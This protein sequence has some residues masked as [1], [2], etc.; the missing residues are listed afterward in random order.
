MDTWI[1]DVSF[2]LC[3][4][5][6]PGNPIKYAS[7]SFVDL[8]GYDANECEGKSVGPLVGGYSILCHEKDLAVFAGE[9]GVQVPAVVHGM[10]FLMDRVREL[11]ARIRGNPQARGHVLQ[12]HRR[13]DGRALVC[14]M[15]VGRGSVL[16]WPCYAVVQRPLQITP[17]ELLTASGC[18][19]ARLMQE[20]SSEMEALLA[21]F[22]GPGGEQMLTEVVSSVLSASLWQRFVAAQK[23]NP[24][25]T[26]SLGSPSTHS[27]GS[28]RSAS[29]AKSG[30]SAVTWTSS[31]DVGRAV[32]EESSPSFGVVAAEEGC[33][34]TDTRKTIGVPDSLLKDSGDKEWESVS[35][36]DFTEE[37]LSDSAVF[38]RLAPQRVLSANSRDW[39]ELHDLEFAFMLADPNLP[40][41]PIV[42][43]SDR[44]SQM[45]HLPKQALSG[46]GLDSL[47]TPSRSTMRDGLD[48]ARYGALCDDCEFNVFTAKARNAEGVLQH[49]EGE[50][51]TSFVGPWQDEGSFACL[52]LIRQVILDNV[53]YLAGV[54]S[55]FPQSVSRPCVTEE[56]GAHA[57]LVG[58]LHHNFLIAEQALAA[59]FWTSVPFHRQQR[60]AG[61]GL[62]RQCGSRF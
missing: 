24:T 36:C 47:L 30:S 57:T 16:G 51:I 19:Y 11:S 26:R 61:A 29:T 49:E 17:A 3:D 5:D 10:T 25:F 35:D 9:V 43:W 62:R 13:Q 54:F 15:G 48:Q 2:V 56:Q 55:E 14:D 20:Q 40:R 50:M 8:Y 18:A 44:F 46:C 52:A 31:C 27:G 6:A 41:C 42:A 53:M 21:S 12:L 22:D 38:E 1:K 45:T 34:T 59:L 39:Q 4:F 37:E 32:S 58:V 7:Q 28:R 33:S 60:M 23:T